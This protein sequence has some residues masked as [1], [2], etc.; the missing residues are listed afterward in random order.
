MEQGLLD[1]YEES[2]KNVAKQ[3]DAPASQHKK[4]AQNK[5]SNSHLMSRM[6]L[7]DNKAGMQGLDKEK[8]N[9]IIYEASKGKTFY[10]KMAMLSF[11][12]LLVIY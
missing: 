12:A 4:M 6:L 3:Y 7:N 9:Q 8:I 5:E 1:K 2:T 11:V 10:P